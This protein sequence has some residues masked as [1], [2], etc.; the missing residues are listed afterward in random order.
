MAHYR[1]SPTE[2]DTLQGMVEELLK[3]DVIQ[4]SKS[5]CAV[6]ALLIPKKDKTRCMCI[7]SRAINKITFKYRFPIPC[8]DDMLDLLHGSQ[9]FSI[10]DLRSGYHQ[11]QI[12]PGDEWMPAFKTNKA[13]MSGL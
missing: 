3:K 7:D 8:L 6:P 12:R 13:F 5:P 9:V 10:I 11:L 1:M 2:C 4:E